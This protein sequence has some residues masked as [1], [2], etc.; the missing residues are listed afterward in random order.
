MEK[1][2]IDSCGWIFDQWVRELMQNSSKKKEGYIIDNQQLPNTSI[3]QQ[4][5]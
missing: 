5:F 1:N 3:H 2:G 4:P